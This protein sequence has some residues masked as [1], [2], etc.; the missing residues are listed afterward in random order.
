MDR[1]VYGRMEQ[2]LN[3]TEL[4]RRSM[5]GDKEA[6]GLLVERHQTLVYALIYSATGSMERSE[7][8]AQETFLR[9]WQ[10]VGRLRDPTRFRPWLCTLARN[11][12]TR[13][14]Q[15]RSRDVLAAAVPLEEAAVPADEVGPVERLIRRERQE[16]V[17]SALQRLPRKYREPLVLFYSTG[18]S[19]REVAAELELSEHVVRQRLYRGRRLLNAEVSSL[20]EDTLCGVRPGQAFSAAVIALL[21]AAVSPAAAAVILGAKGVPAANAA[22]AA[23][24][25]GAILGPILGLLGGLLGTWADIRRTRSPRERRFVIWISILVWLLGLGLIMLPLAL[26]VAGVISNSAYL[27]CFAIFFALLLPLSSL[28]DAHQR[29]IQKEEGTPPPPPGPPAPISPGGIY[30]SFGGSIFGPLAWLL[31]L[32]GI[33]H[34][35]LAFATVLAGGLLTFLI[36]THLAYRRRR[37][38]LAAWVALG[39]LAAL[40]FTLANLRWNAWMVVYRHSSWYDPSND[41]TLAFLDTIMII[42]FAGAALVFWAHLRRQPPDR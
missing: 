2:M 26:L 7:E 6:F 40:T 21:P 20:V 36:A 30:A 12:A 35:W 19:V 4:L 3:E 11:L 14:G 1:T 24:I 31:I 22:W 39:G 34:D 18:R 33:V 15:S 29:R 16:G 32:T 28:A 9:A 5:A 37:R 38:D 27:I 13:A 41:V 42:A 25:A 17:W 10:N 23:I 8:L